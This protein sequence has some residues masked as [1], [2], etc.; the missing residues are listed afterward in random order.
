MDVIP[1]LTA[2]AKNWD[3]SY[4][5]VVFLGMISILAF[6]TNRYDIPTWE[7]TTIGNL[8]QLSPK[9]L[10]PDYRYRKGFIIYVSCMLATYVALCFIGPKIV[11]AIPGASQL[12]LVTEP[13]LWPMSA[14]VI[15][16]AAGAMGDE[17]FPGNI[18]GFFRR[19][20]H[21]MAFIPT[22]VKKLSTQLTSFKLINW[23]NATDANVRRRIENESGGVSVCPLSQ[24][25][26]LTEGNLVSWARG[27]IL[28]YQLKALSGSTYDQIKG[29]DENKRALQNLS[30]LRTSVLSRLPKF[31][32][33]NSN[34]DIDSSLSGDIDSFIQGTATLLAAT[35]LQAAPNERDLSEQI[36]AFG[37]LDIDSDPSQDWA[38]FVRFVAVA[39]AACTFV[40][41]VFINIAI[42]MFP[43]IFETGIT[44]SIN[45]RV[46][47]TIVGVGL[48][49]VVS[50]F[51]LM[52]SRETRLTKRRWEEGIGTYFDF[53]IKSGSIAGLAAAFV[54]VI[55][56][57][58]SLT[59]VAWLACVLFFYTTMAV[60]TAGFFS[61]H[62]RSAARTGEGWREILRTLFGAGI[63]I[64]AVVAAICAAVL[65]FLTVRASL[66]IE[67]DQALRNLLAQVQDVEKRASTNPSAMTRAFFTG[68]F[69]DDKHL[70]WIDQSLTGLINVQH[71]ERL[72]SLEDLCHEANT[73]LGE[74]QLFEEPNNTCTVLARYKSELNAQTGADRNVWTFGTLLQELHNAE[75]EAAD[76]RK[77]HDKILFQMA[78]SGLLWF[79]AT[80]VV[81]IA[82]RFGRILQL[83]N[84][85][86]KFDEGTIERLKERAKAY[87]GGSDAKADEW[88]TTPN[89][90]I[91]FLSP[92]EGVRYQSCRP[93]LFDS[94]PVRSEKPDTA[95]NPPQAPVLKVVQA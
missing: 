93:S 21:E 29:Q 45:D 86:D 17:R 61:L 70:A 12:P 18:E 7:K 53:A 68:P 36:S 62:V 46:N 35:L 51:I 8:A 89:A 34:K 11:N 6:S 32:Q 37:L 83:H 23:Y 49:Y 16:A 38:Q 79:F 63:W 90:T 48:L 76:E 14:A 22:A 65:S 57:G 27:N 1:Y 77:A 91:G 5:F 82:V 44:G 52:Y 95:V 87:F 78:F 19:K 30:I 72:Q 2:L 71:S 3:W 40:V 13:A 81:G 47:P 94:I 25:A 88:L 73:D 75:K 80:L 28:L 55:F 56:S 60:V 64:N 24:V 39:A 92:L 26:Q 31:E 50:T 66:D 43:K 85:I 42:T 15:L 41:W 9:S 54:V 67:P 74:N 10:A 4:C 84:Q 20:S 69:F 58:I 33:D 59:S